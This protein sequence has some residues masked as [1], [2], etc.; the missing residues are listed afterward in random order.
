MPDALTQEEF[1]DGVSIPRNKELM[2]IFKDLDMVEQLG[3]G[4]PRILE[5]YGKESFK[6]SPNFL[7]MTFEAAHQDEK[8]SEISGGQI[9]GQIGDL[10]ERQKD[11]LKIIIKNNKTTRNDIAHQLKIN[12]S[13]VS[14]HL[15]ILK[16]KGFIERIGGTRG[17]WFDID[18][19][20]EKNSTV[21]GGQI[22]GQMGG[23]I[24]DLT[25]RQKEVLNIIVENNKVTRKHIANQ[26]KINGSA[27]SKHLE[28][29]KEK[30]HIERIGGMRGYWKVTTSDIN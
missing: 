16:E 25:D 10:T 5:S 15:E 21:S 3:S 14:K 11:I 29:L 12:E 30:G 6:F 8:N 4:V 26:L 9:G 28:I 22:G 1:F 20:D 19:Q 24:D 7:R 17:H 2:R 27:V 23:Q 13:A 18:Y